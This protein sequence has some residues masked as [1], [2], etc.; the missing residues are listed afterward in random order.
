MPRWT[1]TGWVEGLQFLISKQ[2]EETGEERRRGVGRLQGGCQVT[3][4]QQRCDA[5]AAHARLLQQGGA[6]LAYGAVQPPPRNLPVRLPRAPASARRHARPALPPPC[7]VLQHELSRLL[8]PVLVHAYLNLV[9]LG[10]TAE[11]QQL[12]AAHKQRF[13]DVA[14]G[15]SKL[16]MQVRPGP[17]HRS[18]PPQLRLS[19]VRLC[20]HPKACT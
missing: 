16:R 9:S 4:A 15:A 17:R 19:C 20:A 3:A 1:C 11:A 2:R 6:L 5:A 14:G 18:P 8:Y 13:I 12:L 7:P 10:A